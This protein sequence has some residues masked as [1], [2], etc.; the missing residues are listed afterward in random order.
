MYEKL[1][2]AQIKTGESIEIGVVTTPEDRLLTGVEDLLAHK[3]DEWKTHIHAALSGETDALET[4][5]YI[6]LL[7]GYPVANVMT[8]ER[9]GIGILG[10]VFTRPEHRRKGIC[11]AVMARQMDHFRQRGG[12]VLTL[13]TGFE[14]PPY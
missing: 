9:N 1:D 14:R 3:G 2:N 6:G 4:R 12:H 5:F 11:Q 13:G 10:H 7:D 8:V